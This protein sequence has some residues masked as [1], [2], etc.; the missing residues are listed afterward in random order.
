MSQENVEA[1]KR[2]V[3]AGNRFDTDALTAE[4]APDVEWHPAIQALAEGGAPVHRG[5]EGVREMFR[6]FESVFSEAQ[7][8]FPDIRDLGDRVVALGVFRNRGKA[9]GAEVES[10]LGYVV[11][12]K[13][14]K[15]VLVRTYLDH[16]QALE[17]AGLK[18]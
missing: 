9:S 4:L 12:F 14:G 18:E 7:M 13:S 2:A 1:F 15:V 17:A 10:P 3:K 16:N 8:E 11:D 5:H 6:D